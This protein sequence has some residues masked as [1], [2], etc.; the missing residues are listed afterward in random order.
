[1]DE[2]VAKSK[3]DAQYTLEYSRGAK[4]PKKHW[5]KFSGILV[6]DGYAPYRTVFYD[7]VK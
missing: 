1:M 2:W 4:I 7:N 5:K 6:S 3:T